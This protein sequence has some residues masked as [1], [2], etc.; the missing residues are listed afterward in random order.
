MGDA[1]ILKSVLLIPGVQ[2]VGE[3]SSGFNVRGGSA[4][5]N[6]I[7]LYGAPLYNASHFFG[8]FSAVNSDIIKD[9]T[10]YKGGIPARYGGRI[11]S[12]LD[13]T[14]RNG[15]GKDF[16]GRAGISPVTTY[17]MAEGPIIKE[18]C[19]FLLAGRTTYSNWLFKLLNDPDLRNS[20]AAFNDLNGR[21]TFNIDR[22]NKI[23]LSAYRSHDAFRLN[24]DTL[25]NYGNSIMAISWHHFF[26]GSLFSVLTLNNSNYR[27]DISGSQGGTDRFI[28]SHK[29]NSTGLK[30]DFNLL[31]GNHEFNFGID[32]TRYGVAPGSYTPASDSSTLI[33]EVIERERALETGLYFED[34]Y[35]ITDYLSLTAG[36]RFSSFHVLGPRSVMLYDP[37]FSKSLSTIIDTLN[38]SKKD[39]CKSY[40]GPEFRISLNFRL[41]NNSAIKLNYNRTRQYLHL[42][43]NT[44]SISPYRYLEIK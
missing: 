30:Y 42:L 1:D 21:I 10:L 18:K 17:L 29:I 40:A 12:V 6:L 26:S 44:T 19:T 23:D 33:P 31:N 35:T 9:V 39:I 20:S 24:S 22:S 4:D 8:F 5:Q 36:L 7:L 3:G 11:S 14:A 38:F 41:S 13:I 28:L 34:R 32:L 15:N 25:Y 2:S 27:Y 16:S 37:S 43:S